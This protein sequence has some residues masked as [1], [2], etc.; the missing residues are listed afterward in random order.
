MN[1]NNEK[2]DNLVDLIVQ[3]SKE[4]WIT[5]NWKSTTQWLKLVSEY[6]EISEW[7]LLDKKELIEDAIW[8]VFVVMTNLSELIKKEYNI[9]ISYNRR[10]I[11][12]DLKLNYN[13]L[14]VIILKWNDIIW[15][16][17]DNI[18]KWN[19]EWIIMNLYKLYKI[20]IQISIWFKIDF[21]EA[22]ENAYNEIKDRKWFLNSNWSFIK[23][24]DEN[25]EKLYNEYLKSIENK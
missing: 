4:R 15:K 16:L 17:S 7:I 1:I 20:L 6:W 18:I 3:R 13:S 9:N 8:D 23:E 24:E 19:V 22:V 10:L 12:D 11:K 2:L 14:E 25:Y 21:I 5:V